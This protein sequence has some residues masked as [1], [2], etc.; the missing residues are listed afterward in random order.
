MLP[1]CK[2]FN[3]KLCIVG[4]FEDSLIED[5]RGVYVRQNYELRLAPGEQLDANVHVKYRWN[6]GLA[7][8]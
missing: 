3:R 1:I 6:R 4:R 8:D 5:C 7:F 2:F